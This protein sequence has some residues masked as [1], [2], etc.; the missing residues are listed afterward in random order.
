MQRQKQ[1]IAQCGSSSV[2]IQITSGNLYVFWR[3]LLPDHREFFQRVQLVKIPFFK[4]FPVRLLFFIGIVP[5]NKVEILVK[6][7]VTHTQIG[8]DKSAR[9]G[10]NGG[11]TING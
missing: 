10:Q 7:V 5:I 3:A 8:Y 4:V 2:Y 6:I 1:Q 9:A 11:K